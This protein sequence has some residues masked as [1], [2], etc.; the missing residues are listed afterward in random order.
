MHPEEDILEIAY[1][2]TDPRLGLGLGMV[3]TSVLLDLWPVTDVSIHQRCLQTNHSL[4]NPDFRY[5]WPPW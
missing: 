1:H 2:A 3:T 5:L 4:P